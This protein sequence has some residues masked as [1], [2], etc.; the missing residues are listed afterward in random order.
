MRGDP[1]IVEMLNDVLTAELT[2]INQ[3]YVHYKMNENWGYR[4]LAARLREES[5]EE[6]RH[7]DALIERILY[8]EGV[9]NMQRLYPVKVGE[10]VP[11]QHALD[12]ALEKAA[13]E[14]LNKGIALCRDRGDNGTRELLAR[15]LVDEEKAI[16]WTE[17]QLSII[18]E[19]GKERYL[20]EHIHE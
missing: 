5:I 6:M 4:R 2:A 8:F 14:R 12:L 15:M 16:D 18:A 7:A 20:A 9:P 3:Y 19:I 17:A 11:E 10:N 13:V 1:D